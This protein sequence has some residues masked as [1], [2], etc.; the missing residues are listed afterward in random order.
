MTW[1]KKAPS[2]EQIAV[3]EETAKLDVVR[4]TRKTALQRLMRKLDGIDL[5]D[6]LMGIGDALKDI[7]KN[8][9]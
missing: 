1:F 2:P 9:H 6:G 8:G 3:A 7:P 5:E 4:Q